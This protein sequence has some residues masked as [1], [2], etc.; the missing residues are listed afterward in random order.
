MA[1]APAIAEDCLPARLP[2]VRGRLSAARPLADLT[3]FR[4]GGPAE[5]LFQP[6]DEDDLTAFLAA[7]PLGVPV[8]PIGVGSNLLVRD[9]GV[10]GV[11][12]RLGRG[13]AGIRTEGR[14][15][16]A[17]AA[18]LDARVAEAA[19]R[20]GIAG[21][22]FL[23]TIP[24]TI[25]GALAMNAGCYG[26]E[27]RDVL[28]EAHA[29]DR[30]G[31]KVVIPAAEMG[32]SYRH[33]AAAEGLVFTAAVFEGTR[34]TPEAIAAR[35]AGLLAR[36]EA[37]QPMRTRTGGSTF[38]NPSGAS[39]TGAENEDTAMTAWRLID[40]AGARGLRLGAAQVSAKH[41]NFLINTGAAS[42]AEL[43]AL[44]ELVRALVRHRTGVDLHWEIRRIGAMLPKSETA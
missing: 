39:S 19:A 26:R 17:G 3:W 38:R 1:S 15:V 35:M 24:G 7:L 22:E 18:A 37:T 25:G 11:V 28:V 41:C 34:D 27:T 30:S 33:A 14:R 20:A 36:R 4:V 43:E 32:F 29:L 31:R 12:V 16:I 2:P 40:A 8:T 44:G 10:P 21:L 5:V 9:G 6:A 23:R 13:F 42:A